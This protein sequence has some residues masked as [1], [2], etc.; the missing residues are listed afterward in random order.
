MSTLQPPKIRLLEVQKFEWP[1]KLRMPF[2]FGAV[3]HTH[4]RQAVV[5]VRIRQENG[6]EGWGVAAESLAA[7]WFEKDP[8]YSDDD[9]FRQLRKAIEIAE[10]NYLAASPRTAFAMFA[11]LY[12]AQIDAGTRAKLNPL[13]ASYGPALID[14]AI[15]DALCRLNGVSFY[16][17]MQS[18]LPGMRPHPTIADLG[19]FDFD[20]FLAALKPQAY[21]HARHT[22][23]LVDPIVAGDQDAAARVNDGLPETLEEVVRTYGHRYYKL[24]VGGNV[25]AD[26]ER[27]TRIAG[28]LDRT[29]APYYASLDGNEQYQDAAGVLELWSGIAASP[30]LRRLAQAI[31]F[32]EQPIKR[33]NALAADIAA[34]ARAKPV[35]I[36][37]SD[38]ELGTFPRARQL[39]YV[40]ISSKACKGFYKSFIN[41][42]RC[43]EWNRESGENRHFLSAEDLT[44]LA[45]TCVQQDLALISLLGLTHVERNGH[46][47]VDGFAGRRREEA[48]RFATAHPD[49]YARSTWG[50]RLKIA[51]GRLAIGSL[52]CIGFGSSVEPDVAGL[53]AMPASNWPG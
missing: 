51:D 36:D 27:L 44:T 30:A 42:A 26:L 14:R 46:H 45:G 24:K 18:N 48:E 20:R 53:E 33:A 35:I 5:R 15:L 43:Q 4:G 50:P 12:T 19:E 13:V 47:F 8:A 22:V 2:R 16:A 1:F 34:L 40:G 31:I 37:E 23:G 6:A 17:A 28:V 10:A 41:L 11:D 25:A 49:L 21:V 3:T 29:D 52:D 38:G 7:K 9:N 39:G 32:I